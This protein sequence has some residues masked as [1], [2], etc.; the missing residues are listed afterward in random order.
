MFE[1]GNDGTSENGEPDPD[2]IQGAG[3]DA[4]GVEPG[5]V[6]AGSGGVNRAAAHALLDLVLD[7]DRADPGPVLAGAIVAHAKV[8]SL[9]DGRVLGVLPG[10]EQS[11]DWANDGSPTAVSWL[12]KPV[13]STKSWT[14][15]WQFVF[16]I[17]ENIRGAAT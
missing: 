15:K 2:P 9:I 16:T 7:A 13:T 14:N 1:A 12:V 5:E 4:E 8:T 6:A 3:A 10:W 11:G 17:L